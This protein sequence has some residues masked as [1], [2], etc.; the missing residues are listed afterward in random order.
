MDDL[1]PRLGS[2]ADRLRAL[3]SCDPYFDALCEDCEWLDTRIAALA[4][5]LGP[6]GSIE[7]EQMKRRRLD[8]L[9]LILFI[10]EVRRAA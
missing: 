10:A 8:T 6:I 1:S 5:T 2:H 7:V 3:R 9:N 4:A